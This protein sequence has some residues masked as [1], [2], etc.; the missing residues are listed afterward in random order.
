M[1]KD[2]EVGRKRSGGKKL[3][4]NKMKKKGQRILLG[5]KVGPRGLKT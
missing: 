1:S 5:K 2:R 4:I 3:K